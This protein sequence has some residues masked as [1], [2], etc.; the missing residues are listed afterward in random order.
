MKRSYDLVERAR[1]NRRRPRID[2]C[3][4]PVESLHGVDVNPLYVT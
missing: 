3:G 2:P 1:K 4:I